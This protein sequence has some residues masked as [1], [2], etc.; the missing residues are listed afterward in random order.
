MNE[1]NHS[2]SNTH[3]EQ[4]LYHNKTPG[5]FVRFLQTKGYTDGLA[6]YAKSLLALVGESQQRIKGGSVFPESKL[7]GRYQ[8]LG[9]KVP[10]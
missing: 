6:S 7:I 3:F 4:L 8:P 9:F 10:N 1:R 2:S 5:S